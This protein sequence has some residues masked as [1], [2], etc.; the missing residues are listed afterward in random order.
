[1]KDKE[2]YQIIS[3]KI[4]Y[5]LHHINQ[6]EIA[7]SE[8]KRIL[9]LK[10]NIVAADYVIDKGVTKT[11]CHKFSFPK[12]IELFQRAGF[13]LSEKRL[14]EPDLAFFFARK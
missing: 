2:L 12:M 4:V 5:A 7:L 1:V 13:I 6:P 9:K 3:G 11:D 8:I 14:L 10:G